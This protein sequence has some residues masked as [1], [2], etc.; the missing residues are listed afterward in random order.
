MR[1]KILFPVLLVLLI[2]WNASAQIQI[3]QGI[4]DAYNS[5]PEV[6]NMALLPLTSVPSASMIAGSRLNGFGRHPVQ[7]SFLCNTFLVDHLGAGLRINFDRMGL[8]S[9]TDIQLGLVYY[10]FLSKEK[11]DGS[12]LKKAGD[13]FSFF[14]AGHYTQDWLNRKNIVVLDPNDPNLYDLKSVAQNGNAS[15]G[16]AFLRENKY[17]VGLSAYQ[18]LPSK[19]TFMNPEMNNY[20]K[21]H[22]F[23]TVSYTFNFGK[24][25]NFGLELHAIAL[26]LTLNT[27]QMDGGL[28]FKIKKVCS[29]GVSY[30]TNKAIKFDVG[31]TTKSWDF[32]YICSYGGSV[33]ASTS[34][35]KAM[36]N[37]IFVK[38]VINEGRRL[39][40]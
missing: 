15:A 33:A 37:M 20:K 4:N 34:T 14:L 40:R 13:K 21:P 2:A 1:R 24:Y 5:V 31:F 23:A 7:A 35:Y 39:K 12:N 3:G 8:L 28:E 6:H 36:N 30:K 32:G 25:Q 9:K 10:V 19:S 18:L 17:Y 11:T 29:I 26:F 27:Y 22:Y 38:R 16:I